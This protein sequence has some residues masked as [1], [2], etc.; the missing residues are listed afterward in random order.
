MKI[1]VD[2]KI[3][4]IQG[5]FEPFAQVEYVN[6]AAIL[7]AHVQHAHALVVRTR[8]QCG[9]ALLKH[10]AVKFIASA[11]IGYDH[12]DTDFCVRNGIE[13]TNAAGCNSGAV[14]QYVA[15]ALLELASKY[16]LDLSGKTLGIIGVGNV[17]KRVLQVAQALGLRVL[18]CDP[19][20]E[21]VEKKNDF[22]AL[23]TIAQHSDFVT[24]HV[25]L[26]HSGAHKT[27]HLI[28]ADFFAQLKR[29][30]FF[31]NSSRG[32]VVDEAALKNALQQKQLS[33]VAL[34][35]WEHEPNIDAELL[36]MVDI[37]TPHVAGYS[38]EG[39]SM[40]TQM[41]V[42]AVAKFFNLPLKDWACKSL[43]QFP[44]QAITLDCDK[45]SVQQI[46]CELTRHTY[47][48]L[49]DDAALRCAPAQGEAL[50]EQYQYRRDFSAYKVIL[51]NA[52]EAQ[53]S[54]VAQIFPSTT[55]LS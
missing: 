51:R 19:P 1:V 47:P 53:K 15:A 9:A 49:L 23:E 11:T 48:I 29:G 40:A 17:G 18:Q 39:K 4:F 31:I 12:I 13:W 22:V 6:G 50:R 21:R 44:N 20:R 27:F 8:T 52:N 41:A 24:L 34:D 16:K 14:Q 37:G 38:V 54:A 3:P 45:K 32:E 35:V 5:V 28:N 2:D 26:A 36:R 55:M 30:A 46:L 43:Q 10:S 25:P 7:H 33:G 42:Q